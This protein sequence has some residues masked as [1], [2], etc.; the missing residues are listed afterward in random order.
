MSEKIPVTVL[1]GYLGAGKTTLLNRILTENHGHRIAV[2]ENEFG[3]I[4]VDQELVIN[5]DEEVFEM[6]NGCICCT[7]RGDLIRILHNLSR[8][9]DRF[10]RVLLET[11][12]L[13]D[14]SPVAQTFFADEDIQDDYTLDGIVTVVDA[15]HLALHIDKS[16][17]CIQQIGFADVMVLN[18]TD[19]V[20]EAEMEAVEAR[21][22]K[23]NPFADVHRAVK[24][25]VA[26]DAVLNVGGFDLD[27]AIEKMPDFIE[28]GAKAEKHDHH[29]SHDHDHE[30]DEHCDHDHHHDH[31]HKPNLHDESVSSIA[32]SFEGALEPSLI[33]PWFSMVLAEMGQDIFRI[34][35]LLHVKGSDRRFVMQSVHMQHEAREDKPWPEGPRLNQIVFI[36][37]NLNRELLED[38]IKGC[39]R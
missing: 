4:G 3:A 2:I 38:G 26:L 24:G 11:T 31:D 27:R 10:D 35:A 6:N 9:R 28:K 20:S 14:P 8:R 12:G 29:H 33:N 22:R 1:T 32:L 19:L 7:V 23:V 15:K 36:G 34:K 30:C 5:A 17:E 37:K 21:I 25:N 39:I 13:A 16:P 18:K